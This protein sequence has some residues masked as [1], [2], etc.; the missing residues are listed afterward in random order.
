MGNPGIV[1]GVIGVIVFSTIL[2]IPGAL[3]FDKIGTASSQRQT[4]FPIGVV[5]IKR[6]GLVR[7]LIGW[8]DNNLPS[9]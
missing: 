9:F 2:V 5:G 1:A 8:V 3:S 6:N 7:I 4:V